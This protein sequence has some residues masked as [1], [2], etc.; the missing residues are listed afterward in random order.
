MELTKFNRYIRTRM[1]FGINIHINLN[2]I[3]NVLFFLICTS[4]F[5]NIIF[6]MKFR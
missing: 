3:R 6:T 4:T 2:S 5:I 1:Q